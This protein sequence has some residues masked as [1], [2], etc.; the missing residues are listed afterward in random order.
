MTDNKDDQS[1]REAARQAVIDAALAYQAGY[2]WL[3]N[4]W[5]NVAAHDRA[6]Q[7]LFMACTALDNTR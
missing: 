7:K 4:G 5:T 2:P 3:R 1:A 6:R